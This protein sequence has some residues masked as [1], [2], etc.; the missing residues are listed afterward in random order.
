MR[1]PRA[2]ASLT[3]EPPALPPPGVGAL[4]RDSSAG[5]NSGCRMRQ[6]TE[7]EGIVQGIR[8]IK[9]GRLRSLSSID[10]DFEAEAEKSGLYHRGWRFFPPYA[11]CRCGCYISARQFAFSRSCGGCDVGDI[12]TARLSIFDHRWFLGGRVVDENPADRWRIS[13]E[14]IPA[15][16][17]ANYPVIHRPKIPPIPPWPPRHPPR[18]QKSLQPPPL[19]PR[20]AR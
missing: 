19:T 15:D 4:M 12:R 2:L 11:C 8:D 20:R 10:A 9:A 3:S 5:H 7:D 17:S 6:M 1:R 13:P 18:S 14:F 16:E